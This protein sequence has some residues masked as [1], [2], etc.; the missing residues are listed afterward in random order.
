MRLQ[1]HLTRAAGVPIRQ[2]FAKASQTET[3]GKAGVSASI[4]RSPSEGEAMPCNTAARILVAGLISPPT[5][6]TLKKLERDGCAF[7]SVDTIAEAESS[8]RAARFDVVLAGEIMADG[9]GY[10]LTDSVVKRS[11]N[12]L[13]AIALS[14]TCLWLP[15]VQH[16]IRTLGDRALNSHNL[17]SE[18]TELLNENVALAEHLVAPSLHVF[19]PELASHRSIVGIDRRT[20][21]EE[22]RGIVFKAA[23]APKKLPRSQL[24]DQ[25]ISSPSEGSRPRK[26]TSENTLTAKA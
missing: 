14:E 10:D 8:L 2:F 1:R 18:I 4:I 12:L 19:V 17:Q 26:R 6:S 5:F 22:R 15:V 7:Q 24:S 16:G 21:P 25:P 13:V 3:F 11:C 20:G 23:P 9:C